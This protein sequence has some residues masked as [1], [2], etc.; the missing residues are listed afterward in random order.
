[1]WRD[2]KRQDGKP[3]HK[4]LIKLT[5][6]INTVIYDWVDGYKKHTWNDFNMSYH[7]RYLDILEKY[8][9]DFDRKLSVRFPDYASPSRELIN[10][11]FNDYF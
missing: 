7:G 3:S 8:L 1:M 9:D 11:T 10:N 2:Y 5:S 6:M 4:V